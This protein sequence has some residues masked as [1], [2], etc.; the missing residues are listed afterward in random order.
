MSKAALSANPCVNPLLILP[1][2]QGL[3]AVH[4]GPASAVGQDTRQLR[5]NQY[6]PSPDTICLFGPAVARV[7][8]VFCYWNAGVLP[9]WVLDGG[10]K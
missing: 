4:R 5:H 9:V 3:A 8:W 7:V 1:A 2:C 6:S 10:V